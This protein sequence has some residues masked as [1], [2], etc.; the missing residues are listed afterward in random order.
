[1]SRQIV[2]INRGVAEL[3]APSPET[4]YTTLSEVLANEELKIGAHYLAAGYYNLGLAARRTDR[5]A[6][7]IRRFNEAIDTLP[8][9]IYA[10]A[11]RRALQERAPE[12]EPQSTDAKPQ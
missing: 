5:E 8:Y 9:S 1:V 3:R 4:A 12:Q 10:R 2:L 7:A 11:A 6:E